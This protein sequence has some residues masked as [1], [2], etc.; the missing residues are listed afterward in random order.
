MNPADSGVPA[1]DLVVDGTGL[2]CVALLLR[3]RSE[4]DCAGPGT[5]VHVVTT[6]PAAPLD[7]PAWCHMT[8]HHYRGPVPGAQQSVH[9]LVLAADALPTR[10]DAPWHPR[11]EHVP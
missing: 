8:G 1:P 6:D 11:D 2:H 3:L 10:A 5:V 9:A 7:L 4:I